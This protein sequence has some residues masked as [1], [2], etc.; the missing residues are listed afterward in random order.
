[1]CFNRVS[2]D[3]NIFGYDPN[4]FIAHLAMWFYG[5]TWFP[6]YLGP[7]PVYDGA[8]QP[9]RYGPPATHQKP[10]LPKD[11]TPCLPPYHYGIPYP[12]YLPAPQS[13]HPDLASVERGLRCSILLNQMEGESSPYLKT[14]T[15]LPLNLKPVQSKSPIVQHMVWLRCVSKFSPTKC[16][17]ISI[18]KSV[19]IFTPLRMNHPL[20]LSWRTGYV[21]MGYTPTTL[22]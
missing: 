1:M 9:P 15:F 17:M 20:A 4:G 22:R 5:P 8:I 10:C 21:T 16:G 11:F 7:R 13:F 19:V 14:F 12:P 6:R 18:Q 3:Y 2:A